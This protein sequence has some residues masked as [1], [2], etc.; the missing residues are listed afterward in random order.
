MILEYMQ[1]RIINYFKCRIGKMSMTAPFVGLQLLSYTEFN[2]S[3][4]QYLD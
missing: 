2:F 1:F 3:L 4:L